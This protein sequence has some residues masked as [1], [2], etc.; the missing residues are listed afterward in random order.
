M[1]TSL[2]IGIAIILVLSSCEKTTYNADYDILLKTEKGFSFKYS[3]FELYDSSTHIFYFKNNH[4]EFKTA[5]NDK[6]SILANGQIIYQGYFL[7]PYSSY[8]PTG[9]FIFSFYKFGPDHFF[10]I[11][12]WFPD[13]VKDSRNDPRLI[14]ALKQKGLLHSGLKVSIDS[15]KISGSQ[16]IFKFTVT[17]SDL[18]DLM[19][20]DPDRAGVN[21]FH[22][23]TNGLS[24]YDSANNLIFKSN[25]E[26]S[27]PASFMD[28]SV[29]WLSVLK[30]G[31]SRQFTI[32]YTPSAP[33]KL[34][35]YHASFEFPGMH[36]QIPKDQLYQNSDR[37]WLGD[38]QV[39]K[40]ITID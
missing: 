39:N 23:F 9:P 13:N 5:S 31:D 34:G 33:I 4:P 15:I 30:S 21:L 20:L 36:F 40:E 18:S 37:I 24:M 29:D 16:L 3:D 35:E 14:D 32:N 6:F 11:E 1:K 2:F 27:S 26:I 7:A 8:I 22:Y 28:W 19:I 38:I 12:A 17:N 25:I 10:E